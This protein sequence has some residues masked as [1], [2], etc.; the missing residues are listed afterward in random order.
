MQRGLGASEKIYDLASCIAFGD[1][2]RPSLMSVVNYVKIIN[3]SVI[4]PIK[5][6]NSA[7]TADEFD[8]SHVRHGLLQ[9]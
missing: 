9:S 3:V 1:T 5:M 2:Y 7:E 8:K 6:I 4:I